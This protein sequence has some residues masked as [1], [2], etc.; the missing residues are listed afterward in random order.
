M[1]QHAMEEERRSARCGNMFM[2][3]KCL[4]LWKERARSGLLRSLSAQIRALQ[5]SRA[6]TSGRDE[7]FSGKGSQGRTLQ[8]CTAIAI[9][10]VEEGISW[11]M[12]L[13]S[14]LRQV[15]PVRDLPV[16]LR[17]PREFRATDYPCNSS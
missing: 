6:A 8:K 7:R 14:T 10:A 15:P 16:G 13:H 12:Q 3:L 5:S 17:L 11:V 1:M 9:L 4:Q 2:G